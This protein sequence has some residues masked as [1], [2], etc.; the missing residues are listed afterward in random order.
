MVL[1]TNTK[2]SKK[3]LQQSCGRLQQKIEMQDSGSQK[4]ELKNTEKLISG[5]KL[6]F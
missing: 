2:W 1:T 5:Y 4:Q 3:L 6:F